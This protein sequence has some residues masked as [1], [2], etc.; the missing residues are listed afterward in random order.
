MGV[1]DKRDGHSHTPFCK[2]GSKAPMEAYVEQAIALGFTRYTLTEHPP[3]PYQWIDNPQ[4]MSE[5]AME[6]DEL[7]L[8][9]EQAWKLKQHY[10]G[11]I[12]ITVGLELDFLFDRTDFTMD[13]VK[14]CSD[15]LEEAVVSVHYL[16]GV[17]GMRCIDYTP[18]DFKTGLLA[19]YNSM[20]RIIDAY[21]DH[22]ELA[23][24]LA[25]DLP[26]RTR[27]GHINLIE[28][29]RTELPLIDEN[30]IADRL[31]K[32]IPR[33]DK[34]G[35]GI[36]VNMAGLRVATCG[37]P[38]APN[39]FVQE[40]RANKI[41]CVYGSDAHK[42]EQVGFGWDVLEQSLSRHGENTPTSIG[43]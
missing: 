13:I 33:L 32:I 6:A 30:Q 1:I 11:K 18:D 12:E 3:L 24:D 40:C 31:K 7:P 22:V 29:F 20:E 15:K 39:W 34:A 36:D 21:Y 42:P 28:K 17:G 43:G 19:Y 38:Y 23:I 14:A 37:K 2:H 27:I 35:V 16:P 4:L 9:M 41:E 10:T 8:Y 5:L 25:A 26:F